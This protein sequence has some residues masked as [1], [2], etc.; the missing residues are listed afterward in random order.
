MKRDLWLF[1]LALAL[2]LG[3]G[4][5]NDEGF[6]PGVPDPEIAGTTY[7]GLTLRVPAGT[8]ATDDGDF[9]PAGTYDGYLDISR[10]D[11]Y[12]YSA[13]DGNLMWSKKFLKEDLVFPQNVGQDLIKVAA[14]FKAVPGEVIGV[15]IINGGDM[16]T[17]PQTVDAFQDVV[18]KNARRST[19]FKRLIGDGFLGTTQ[20]TAG[21]AGFTVATSSD[22]EK[23]TDP[24]DGIT[25]MYKEFITMSGQ[26][27]PL[28]IE[29]EMT[30]QDVYNGMNTLSMEV[31]K[32]VAK[33]IVT[34]TAAMEIKNDDNSTYGIISNVT[35]SVAQGA[36][37]G[38]LFRQSAP[39][40]RTMS[41]GFNFI[42]GPGAGFDYNDNAA[43]FFEY[44]DL[45]NTTRT[46]NIRP[47][48]AN[49]AALPGV[50][51]FPTTHQHGDDMSTSGY[52]KGNTAYALVRATFTPDPAM[53]YNNAPLAA[54]GTFYLGFLDRII[55]ADL[56]DAQSAAGSAYNSQDVMTY[57]GGKMLYFIWLNPDNADTPSKWLNSPVLRNNIY[58]I[59]IR[60]FT[61]LGANWNP[62]VPTDPE[63]PDPKPEGPEPPIPPVDP[64]D[65]LGDN[66]T[67][68]SVEVNT[69][70]WSVHYYQKYL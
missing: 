57:V 14:P 2:I 42:P 38:D 31:T 16:T 65:P 4:S 55:Y 58:H 52:R 1:L 44:G 28:I 12:L 21:S 54:D 23:I 9:N 24:K 60:S 19:D 37:A 8:R 48:A 15:V 63:N 51:L 64:V 61:K 17:V 50:Y 53:V 29:D 39:D 66:E 27:N 6:E 35:Y 10:M 5:C 34:T 41:Q 36:N 67:Y 32:I 22:T 46:V 43:Q 68:M 18:Y 56:A 7:M 20:I 59:N 62:L 25:E 70:P 13:A 49:V 33:A 3:L 30:Q 26:S 69:I 40:G 11:L 45:L 47:A